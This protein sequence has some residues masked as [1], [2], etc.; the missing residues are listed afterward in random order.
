MTAEDARLEEMLKGSVKWDRWGPYVSERQW[1]TVREDYSATGEAWNYFPYEHARARAYRWGEDGIAGISD[2]HQRACL[3]LGLWN[4][5]DPWLKER[6]FGLTN[7]EGNHGEDV[8]EYYF[9][10]EATPTYSYMKYL[11]KYPQGEFPYA[12]LREENRRRGKKDPEYELLDTGIFGENR[13]FDV[14]I[15]YAKA[16]PEDILIRVTAWNRGPEAARLHLAPSVWF[17]N[18]WAWGR[19]TRAPRLSMRKESEGMRVIELQHWAMGNFLLAAEGAPEMLFTNNETNYQEVFGAENPGPY[20]KDGI[21]RYIVQGKKDGV[22]PAEMG[23]KAA[24]H[25]AQEIAAGGSMQLRLRLVGER[26]A[27]HPMPLWFGEDFDK[28]FERRAAELDEFYKARLLSRREV[29]ADAYAVQKQ[30]FA[31]LLWNKQSYHYNVQQ[32]LEGDPGQPA[33]PRERLEGRNSRW[34]HLNNA[35]VISMPDKW[36]YPWYAAWDL[37]FHCVALALVDPEFAKQQLLLFMREWYMHPSGQVPAYEWAFDDVNPP[38]QAWAALRV[39]AIERRSRGKG[40]RGFL[41]RMFHKLLLNFTWWVNRKD[42]EDMNVF[43]GGFLGLDNIGMFDRSKPL[44]HGGVL[45]QSDGTSWMAMYCLSMLRMALE[46]AHENPAYEDVASKFFEHF[47]YI[48]NAMNDMGGK[49]IGLWDEEDGFYYDVLHLPGGSHLAMKVRSMVG[50]IPVFAVETLEPE[51]VDPHPGF[52]SRMEWFLKH[53]AQTAAL[54]DTSKRTEA[55]PRY[56]LSIAN[57]SKLERLLKY[58]FAEE[59]FL[60]GHGVRSLSRYHLEHPYTLRMDGAIRTVDYEPA[61]ST[62]DLFGGN[63]NWR[64]P[65]WFPM[66]FLFLEALQRYDF[67]YG[68][69]L[70]VEYPAG[71]GQKHT[72]WEAAA[73]ISKRLVG[74]FLQRD[75]RR[76]VYGDREIF[77]SDP[78]WRDYVLFHEYFHGDLGTGLGASHQTGWTALVAKLIEQNGE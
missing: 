16:M 21:D 49:G 56:M 7:S 36:E 29:S 32:W 50:L 38:V 62:S 71:S 66:N 42:I 3:A 12:K 55:G 45:E 33:P 23:T 63:S 52:K 26:V 1:G 70:Q 9:Y 27:R 11:Y 61:E 30:A 53:H 24:A 77:Q 74:I 51:D 37:G 73:D 8:K 75:G 35:D 60:S 69:D 68:E 54:V 78:Y 47:V 57:R 65:V 20:R 15:E 4:E 14:F 39:Y 76:A 17:R 6:L 18:T 64:G 5:K 34:T 48:A 25:Y 72:L 44:P 31:G 67:Y 40:D 22:N 41:E 59:E 46:L 2:W 58:V 10:L 43:E 13:Y 28:I 19:D